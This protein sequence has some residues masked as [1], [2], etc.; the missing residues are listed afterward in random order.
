[1]ASDYDWIVIGGGSAGL[2][3][4]GLGAQAGAKTL[5]IERYRLGGDC[6]WTGCI[7]SKALLA[8]AHVGLRM[9]R[10]QSDGLIDAAPPLDASAVLA[11]VRETRQRVYEEADDP[12][13]LEGMGVEVASGEAR[14][15]DDRTLA[16]TS[17]DGERR[18]TG[19]RFLI[20][21]GSRPAIPEIEGIHDV[22][23]LTSE[24]I[25]EL[26]DA[27]GRMV[28]IGG[29]PVGIELAQA[30]N[31]LGTHVHVIESG[32]RI[33]RKF[34]RDLSSRLMERL[35]EE[36]VSVRASQSA[37]A[38]G[39]ST[40]GVTVTADGETL[41]TDVLL[42]ATGRTPRLDL[43]LERAGVEYSAHGIT[44]ND[45]GRTNVR[46]IFAAGDVTGRYHL[47]HMSEHMAKVA[48][49]NALLRIPMKF[50]LDN[51]PAVVY[52]EPE[53]ARVGAS[54]DGLRQSGRAFGVY[55]FPYARLDR[56]VTDG[57]M[58]GEIRI[59]ARKLDGKIYGA[60]VLGARAGELVSQ[61]GLA[62]RNGV[63]LR[64]ISDTI[65]PY[66][67]FGLGVRRAAD[68]WYIRKQSPR[69]VRLMQ[70]VFRFR[71]VVN[72]IDEDTIL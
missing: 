8:P 51:V 62:M 66:P 14:F 25:F 32:D 27:P 24:S 45:R 41:E 38:V 3:A 65:H 21:T 46:H 72:R 47:T 10:L 4:A 29:G 70:R 53:L 58:M 44:V 33:L 11:R 49:T 69:L 1:M 2:T 31:A 50:D 71:G 19:R 6:T 40:S 9:R 43:D 34:D 56:A 42:V 28:V 60:A 67:T 63:S 13:I 16:I 48:A 59:Y 20:A 5:L 26:D 30:F 64:K 39:R 35:S 22:P 52:T 37:T 36:G 55:I 7:P 57:D 68:Q 15:I 17:A 23:V 18:V 61:I 54:E 12:S